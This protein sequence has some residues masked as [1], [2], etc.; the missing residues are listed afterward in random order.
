MYSLQII[1]NEFLRVAVNPIG[2]ELFSIY[3]KKDNMEMLWQGNSEF[4]GSRAPVLFPIVG[5]LKNNTTYYQGKPYLI[6]KHG[7][8]RRNDQLELVEESSHSI[9]YGLLA[10]ESTLNVYP[11]R[12]LFEISFTLK[13]NCLII[14]HKVVNKDS[15]VMYFSLGA[16]PAFNCPFKSSEDYEEYEIE[17]DVPEE[18]L[19]SNR[20]NKEGLITDKTRS[21]NL[22]NN[23]LP[24]TKNLFDD[25]ALIFKKIKS[26]KVTLK[27]R[28][29]GKAIVVDFKDFP[30]LGI[31][32][33]PNAPFVC[34]EPWLGYADAWDSDQLIE[35]KEGMIRLQPKQDFFAEYGISIIS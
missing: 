33:K 19:V 18:V 4:W 17:F 27:N 16:H 8:I 12:F 20:L 1:E 26:R 35:N 3:D 34:I 11:F 30:H 28:G 32:A 7:I 29:G 31:W 9:T 15:K 14:R 22:V 2:A 24:L 23:C 5:G 6:P 13:S 25:D 21:V 10:E